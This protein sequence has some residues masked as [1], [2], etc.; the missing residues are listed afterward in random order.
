MTL[1]KKNSYHV[2]SKDGI[3]VEKKIKI[4]S[5]NNSTRDI[6]LHIFQYFSIFFLVFSSLFSMIDGLEIVLDEKN[7]ILSIILF[8][9]LFYG[10]YHWY[11]WVHVIL[12]TLGFIYLLVLYEL[13]DYLQHGFY[14]LENYF[15]K[16]YN[17]YTEAGL[18]YYY[19]GDYDYEVIM[20]ILMVAVVFFVCSIVAYHVIYSGK[21]LIILLV[22]IPFIAI[23]LVVGNIPNYILLTLYVIFI[24]SVLGYGHRNYVLAKKDDTSYNNDEFKF[25]HRV[26]LTIGLWL[27]IMVAVV[28]LIINLTITD[29]FYTEEVKIREVKH[30]IQNTILEI[31]IEKL[32]QEVSE[33]SPFEGKRYI[34]T[35]GGLRGGKLNQEGSVRY[36][37]STQLML[38][39]P[40]VNEALYLKGYVGTTYTGVAWEGIPK[41]KYSK[42][43]QLL[44]SLNEDGFFSNMQTIDLLTLF[45]ENEIA[46]P[47][48][49]QHAN[50]KLEYRNANTS[51][52]YAPYYTLY[53]KD[54]VWNQELYAKPK[55]NKGNYDLY[56]FAPSL[57]LKDLGDVGEQLAG[58]E[59]VYSR[60][61]K[62][63]KSQLG[64][65]NY[66]M[67]EELYREFVYD[68]YTMLPEEGMERIKTEFANLDM[69]AMYQYTK[70]NHTSSLYDIVTSI[71]SYLANSATY[72]LSPGYVPEGKDYI[73]Y[74]LYENHKGYCAH[75]ASAGTVIL[76]AMGIPARYVEGYYVSREDISSGELGKAVE[77]EV[78]EGNSSYWKN[79]FYRNVKVDDSMAHAWV[80]IYVDGFGWYPVEF[81]PGYQQTRHDNQPS[82]E[83]PEQNPE[84]ASLT[85]SP[86]LTPTP[87]PT[88]KPDLTQTPKPTIEPSNPDEI[89]GPPSNTATEEKLASKKRFFETLIFH[90]LVSTGI[91]VGIL[92]GGIYLQ[93]KIRIYNARS[94]YERN[95]NNQG[96]IAIYEKTLEFLNAY[97]KAIKESDSYDEYVAELVRVYELPK[98]E[99]E[100]AAKGYLKAVYSNY[101][102][103]KEEFDKIFT[104]CC[105]IQK[106]K[107]AQSSSIKKFYFKY[108]KILYLP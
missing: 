91:L 10:I 14:L 107:L 84:D 104:I 65:R 106:T 66:F 22:T 34:Q 85:P 12:W 36:G 97:G 67:Y 75:F 54:A 30:K 2:T 64:L 25:R 18:S 47:L 40:N 13:R 3:Q 69:E 11:Q 57:N 81:T 44:E 24:A 48:S 19:V 82:G 72:S 71:Q 38:Q 108:L 45:L 32:V 99:F 20:G 89:T 41:N 15:I 63:T 55:E 105:N 52:L 26:S 9:T 101:V 28:L 90:N 42:Y 60:L 46:L 1:N 7:L 37:Y 100:F 76:R 35:V 98:E 103:T 68:V 80:E 77:I 56:F 4:V 33:I 83:D 70:E 49:I 21:R 86:T 74:F 17:K 88:T 51:F 73:E 94:F 62:G 43:E 8:T 87:T 31:D 78:M 95:T 58:L 50:I 102:M 96:V 6:L 79:T 92:I 23:N 59:T 39:V 53:S 5:V 93:R 16:V 29:R 27:S 61:E